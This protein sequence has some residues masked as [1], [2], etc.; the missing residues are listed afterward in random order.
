M[1]G[2]DPGVDTERAFVQPLNKNQQIRE[3]SLGKDKRL[4]TGKL[5]IYL[6]ARLNERVNFQ[7]PTSDFQE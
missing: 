6:R 2:V 4:W 7:L 5:K 1:Y 3:V